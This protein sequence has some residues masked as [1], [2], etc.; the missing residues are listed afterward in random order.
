VLRALVLAILISALG[1]AVAPAAVRH[2]VPTNGSPTNPD[3]DAANPCELYHG[4]A[5]AQQ[6]GS[7]DEVVLAGGDYTL[8]SSGEGVLVISEAITVHGA[9]GA[10][11]RLTRSAGPGLIVGNGAVLRDVEVR[12][13]G[14]G[15]AAIRAGNATLERVVAV[16]T[17]A[18]AP[19]MSLGSNAIV[20]NSV[21]NAP[22]ASSPAVNVNSG[23]GIQLRHLTAVGG[24]AGLRADG[25]GE[26][27]S[28][29]AINSI[30]RGGGSDDIVAVPGLS[31]FV[32]VTLDHVAYRPGGAPAIGVTIHDSG[33]TVT[34]APLFNAADDFRQAPGS[35]TIDAGRDDNA[36]PATALDGQARIQ[37]AAPD[38]G[39][40]ERTPAPPVATATPTPT[41]TASPAATATPTPTP[42][43]I[44][45]PDFSLP[46]FL[47]AGFPSPPVA[48]RASDLV[49][50]A[51]DADSPILG[52]VIDLGPGGVFAESAC[53]TFDLTGVFAPGQ[54]VKFTVPVI[55]AAAGLQTYTIKIR[56][57]GCTGATQE[58]SSEQTADV[59]PG[60]AVGRAAAALKCTGS[61]VPTAGAEQRIADAVVCLINK[62]RKA[63]RLRLLTVNKKLVASATFQTNDMLAKGYYNHQRPG[64]PTLAKRVR[65]AKY[66]GDSG[67]NLGL[68]SGSLALPAQMLKAWMNSP[69]HR[70]NIL[71]KRFRAIGVSVQAK[72]PLKK[73]KGAAIYTINFGTKK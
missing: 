34:A 59:K 71:N 73:M 14:D 36:E 23:S 66:R 29:S 46:G 25:S 64:G 57:G 63:K 8:D 30:F 53:R 16:S 20:R 33:G 31:T 22:V 69:P 47:E 9:P 7:T 45:P 40:D 55:F 19:A 51:Y 10:R 2:I 12:Q 60:A 24:L 68:G 43:P 65:K 70:A 50:K 61:L 6:A 26:N 17:G 15:E 27:V 1:P 39:A 54:V 4:L 42:S 21:A 38:I 62:T 28:V 37:G 5:V 44:A 3:C 18:N 72:D 13:T 41:P 11:P 48:G 58:S 56:S 52:V 32:D 35:P 67:E 49:I